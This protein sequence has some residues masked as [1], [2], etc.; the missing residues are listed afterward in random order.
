MLALCLGPLSGQEE[1][2]PEWVSTQDFD[3]VGTRL[4]ELRA[5]E[6]L[7]KKA[8]AGC[9]STFDWPDRFPQKILVRLT[10]DPI[11]RID[12]SATGTVRLELNAG[13]NAS[14][15][16]EWLVRAL[17][18]RFAF[19]EGNDRAPPLWL[20]NAVLVKGLL[21]GNPQA[22][23]LLLRRLRNTEIPSVS[24]RIQSY[25]RTTDIGWDYLLYR[26]LEAGGLD[27]RTFQRRLIQ[28]WESGFDWTQ[29]NQFFS[30]L[31]PGLNGAEM[32]LLWRTFVSETTSSESA[33]CLSEN[34]S[35]QELEALARMEVLENGQTKLLEFDSWYLHRLNPVIIK[36]LRQ[37]QSELEVLATRIHPYFFNACHSLNEVLLTTL[38]SDL[39]GYQ[40]AVRKWSQDLL[41]GQQLTYETERLLNALCP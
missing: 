2:T 16:A 34:E 6:E 3:I 17:L 11:P 33:I 4:A 27:K 24:Q 5:I 19:R 31:Y 20:V 38:E 14:V 10:E 37:K 23:T 32:E 21:V 29:L 30:P 35:I 25:D 7:S 15:K 12:S 9:A 28:F 22:N 26:W 1:A 13:L 40:D 41:D 39:S 18:I 36:L 8:L